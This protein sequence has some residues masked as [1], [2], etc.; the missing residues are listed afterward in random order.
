M[1]WLDFYEHGYEQDNVKGYGLIF[2]TYSTMQYFSTMQFFS[3]SVPV[4][5]VRADGALMSKDYH[6]L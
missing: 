5:E 4:S 6:V 2:L 1:Y 3:V